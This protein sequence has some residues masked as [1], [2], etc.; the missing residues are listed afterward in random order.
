VFIYNISIIINS[1][2]SGAWKNQKPLD[3]RDETHDMQS[4][5]THTR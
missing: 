2:G 5:Q 3:A 4:M 1:N